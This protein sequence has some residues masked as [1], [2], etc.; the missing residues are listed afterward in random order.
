VSDDA[1]ALHQL[2]VHRVIVPSAPAVCDVV[3]VRVAELQDLLQRP[4][5]EA[6]QAECRAVGLRFSDD[7]ERMLGVV[8][9]R[10]EHQGADVFANARRVLF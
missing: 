2:F 3:F 5:T 6:L 9:A 4:F 1:A 7:G 8:E 10:V